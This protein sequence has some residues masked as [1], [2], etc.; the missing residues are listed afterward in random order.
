MHVTSARPLTIGFVSNAEDGGATRRNAAI[1][2]QARTA[3]LPKRRA[4]M[5]TKFY[6]VCAATAFVSQGACCVFSLYDHHLESALA[7]GLAS[8]W[9]F[10]YF[11]EVTHG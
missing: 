10:A 4:Q 3:A 1:R 5:F 7:W 6:A 2:F 11:K 9:A 8:L